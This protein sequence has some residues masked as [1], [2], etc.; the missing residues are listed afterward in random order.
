[1]VRNVGFYLSGKTTSNFTT[2]ISQRHNV[3]EVPIEIQQLK[4][5]IMNTFILPFMSKKWEILE[6]NL[7]LVDKINIQIDLYSSLYTTDYLTLYKDVLTIFETSMFQHL[8]IFNL[9]KQLYGSGEEGGNIMM[10]KTPFIRLK[11]EYELYN[12]ILGKPKI[13][14]N[15]SYNALIISDILSIIERNEISFNKIKEYILK[16]YNAGLYSVVHENLEN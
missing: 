5:M 12:L 4:I 10:V 13:S 6:E 15:E 2:L 3:G 14:N 11:A 9:E 7:W 1:M 8:E 16:K